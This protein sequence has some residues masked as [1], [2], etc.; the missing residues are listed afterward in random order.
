MHCHVR[1]WTK[2]ERIINDYFDNGLRTILKWLD[3]SKRTLDP[4]FIQVW[5]NLIIYLEGVRHLMCTISLLIVMLSTLEVRLDL[6]MDLFNLVNEG[7]ISSLLFGNQGVDD[8]G[9]R[10]NGASTRMDGWKPK[11]V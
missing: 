2:L 8:V 3:L 1:Q 11:Q 4:L 9:Y 7:G 6:F 5:P 10:P